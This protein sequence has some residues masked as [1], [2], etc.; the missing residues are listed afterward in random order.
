MSKNVV[1][2]L[3]NLKMILDVKYDNSVY[4]D[5]WVLDAIR[6]CSEEGEDG[7][8]FDYMEILAKIKDVKKKAQATGICFGNFIRE[9]EYQFYKAVLYFY[10]EDF[11][12]A[13]KNFERA[14]KLT[15]EYISEKVK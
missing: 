8:D 5:Y 14:L 6:E 10:G 3:V 12:R 13:L 2:T 15:E 7:N 11:Q 1:D 9:A 4:F